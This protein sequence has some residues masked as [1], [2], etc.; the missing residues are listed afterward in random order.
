MSRQG[1]GTLVV[2]STRGDAVQW[3]SLPLSPFLLR[4]MTPSLSNFYII[5]KWR[6]QPRNLKTFGELKSITSTNMH[7]TFIYQ[8]HFRP[9]PGQFLLLSLLPVSSL[10]NWTQVYF[11]SQNSQLSSHKGRSPG[12]ANKRKKWKDSTLGLMNMNHLL[13]WKLKLSYFDGNG[14]HILKKISVCYP[15]SII[16]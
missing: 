5:F 7:L 3:L 6:T 11:E 10:L 16:N 8:Q 2:C 14:K 12:K 4:R 13:A 15:K 1:W 9:F